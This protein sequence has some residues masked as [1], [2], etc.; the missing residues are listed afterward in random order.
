MSSD[1]EP[2]I[3]G[4]AIQDFFTWY[5]EEFGEDAMA[6]I[7][8]RLPDRVRADLGPSYSK[9]LAFHWYPASATHSA[10]D[11]VLERHTA[12]EHE[13]LAQQGARVVIGKTLRG[14][15]RTIFKTLVSPS[16][17]L[18]TVNTVWKAFHDTGHIETRE[19]GPAHH[20]S[21][22]HGWRA[23]HAFIERLNGFAAKE[24][25][26]AMGCRAVSFEQTHGTD[27]RGEPT[28]VMNMRWKP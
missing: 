10:L 7:W 28:Y 26:E 1:L 11:L 15:Y 22:L 21:E 5:A 24:I 16:R 13:Q 4:A 2:R 3:K 8:A 12:Q 9:L 14:L 19:L 25:Y 27:D 17:Y 6:T 18:R 23:P 20:Y